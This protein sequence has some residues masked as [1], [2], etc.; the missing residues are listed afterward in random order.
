MV[1]MQDTWLD[2]QKKPA[3]TREICLLLTAFRLPLTAYLP[4]LGPRR[5]VTWP[6]PNTTCLT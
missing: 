6:D 3:E 1:T 2:K 4:L 5:K